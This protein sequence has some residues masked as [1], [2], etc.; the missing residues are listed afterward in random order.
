M[1]FSLNSAASNLLA[2]SYPSTVW[3]TNLN[4]QSAQSRSFILAIVPPPAIT[5]QPASLVAMEG[6]TASFSVGTSSNALLFFQWRQDNGA[7]L[8]NLSDNA[9]IVGASSST[10]TISNVTSAN[11]GAY[12]VAVSNAAGTIISSNAFL[13]IIPWRPTITVQPAN[14]TL[15]PGETLNLTVTAVGSQP[16]SYR[17]LKGGTNLADGGP[18]AGA[19]DFLDDGRALHEQV[20]QRVVDP[21]EFGAERREVE[22]RRGRRRWARVVAWCAY[23]PNGGSARLHVLSA[24]GS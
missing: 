21:V 11:V 2:G 14:K 17:W 9:N 15:L 24:G 7:Y 4:D 8:T 16:L 1:T 13:T 6:A 20:V 19:C 3:F 12:S 22:R 5:A 10:L 18:L 23:R